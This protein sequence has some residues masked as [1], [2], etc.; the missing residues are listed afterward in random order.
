L[1][2]VYKFSQDTEYNP[3][4]VITCI[5]TI[6]NVTEYCLPVLIRHMYLAKIQLMNPSRVIP[7][8]YGVTVL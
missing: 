5:H 6:S 4:Y 8:L 3:A 7:W 1:I 2:R